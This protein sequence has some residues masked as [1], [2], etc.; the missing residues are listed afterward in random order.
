M[1]RRHRAGRSRQGSGAGRIT[2]R[3]PSHS[4]FAAGPRVPLDTD[5]AGLRAEPA[6][7]AEAG[8]VE[9][10]PVVPSRVAPRTPD[11]PA[12]EAPVALAD[13]VAA[14]RRPE[15]VGEES[16]AASIGPRPPRSG[17]TP[18]Q[19]RRFIKSRPYV[20]LH[21]LR[22]RFGLNGHDDDVVPVDVGEQR[23][24]VGLPADET[25]MLGELIRQGEVGCELSLDPA[26]PVVVGVFPMRPVPRS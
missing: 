14:D 11:A 2:A 22:R 25:R 5:A 19:L 10:A 8:S 16:Q 20:P 13:A 6:S 23:L 26:T 12:P 17:A 3:G 21:E 15:V 24:W 18:A 7:R 1:G 4:T 9:A